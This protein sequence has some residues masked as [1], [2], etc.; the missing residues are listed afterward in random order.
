MSKIHGNSRKATPRVAVSAWLLPGTYKDF[1][2]IR[3]ATGKSFTVLLTEMIEEYM[4]RNNFL[5]K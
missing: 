4:A 2:G 5:V 3:E 1:V